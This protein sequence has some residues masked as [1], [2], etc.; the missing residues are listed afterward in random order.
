LKLLW[1]LDE[2]YLTAQWKWGSIFYGQMD[3]NLGP[4]GYDGIG[5]SNYGYGREAIALDVGTRDFHLFAQAADLRDEQDTAGDVVHRYFF[6][7]RLEGRITSRLRI[8]LWETTVLA[9]H[10]RSFSG[11]FRNPVTLLVLANQYGRGDAG[12]NVLVGFDIHWRAFRRAIIQ[13][14]I[15]IDDIQYDPRSGP[16][17]YPDRWALS[18][19]G[20]GPLGRQLSWCA[21]YTQ[22]SSLAFRTLNPME[23]LTEAGVGL[24][25]NFADMDQLSLTVS[26]PIDVHWLL[27]PEATLLRQGEGRI[28]DPFPQ[29]AEE[30]GRV[31]QIFIGHVER[32]YRLALGVTGRHGPVDLVANAGFHHVVNAG[33]EEGRTANRFEGRLQVTA[34][35]GRRQ[36]LP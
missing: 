35:L 15:G 6:L 34:G 19:A 36:T 2:A 28:G 26:V 3:R 8:A 21:F 10:D 4:V 27:T 14:Q 1:R 20:Y 16:L 7:H 33:H 12:A 22:A 32:T 17:R 30:A 18:L 29:S 23:N 13:A 25:R 11:R 31:P 24:G 5:L 9:G